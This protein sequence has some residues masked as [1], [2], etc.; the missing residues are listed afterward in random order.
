MSTFSVIRSTTKFDRGPF[1]WGLT[2]KVEWGDFQLP[3]QRHISEAVRDKA[4]VIINIHL[5]SPKTVA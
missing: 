2:L 5:Y 3:S 1:D 4:K